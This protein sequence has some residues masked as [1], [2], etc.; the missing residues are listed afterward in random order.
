MLNGPAH[1]LTL[2]RADLPEQREVLLE[3]PEGPF[4]A[5]VGRYLDTVLDGAP[6]LAP[7]ELGRENLRVVLAA[8]E[9]ARRGREVRL[10]EIAPPQG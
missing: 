1:A 8:Y 9:S 2:Y 5:M 10:D 4:V 7:A 3:N 6:N